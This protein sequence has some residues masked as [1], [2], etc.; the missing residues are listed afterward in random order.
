MLIK[1]RKEELAKQSAEKEQK[2][3]RA[4]EFRQNEYEKR[5][6]SMEKSLLEKEKA[7]RE[8]MK[9]FTFLSVVSIAGIHYEKLFKSKQ[10][11][12]KDKKK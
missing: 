12:R 5:I 11:K 2:I 6:L 9:V 10:A 1:E 3:E 4:K 7:K 8:N